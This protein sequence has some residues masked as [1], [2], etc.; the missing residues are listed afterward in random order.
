MG[1]PAPEI[2]SPGAVPPA[3]Q[4][5]GPEESGADTPDAPD[6]SDAPGTE[7]RKPLRA[8][9]LR[10]L[11]RVLDAAREAFATEG[12]SVSL[13]EIARRAGVGAGTVHRHF[14]AKDDLFR[15]VIARRLN[16]LTQ[17]AQD[18]A[19]A[20]DPGEAFFDFFNRLAA[21]A[22][23]NVALSAAL[24]NP[25]DVGEAILD[26]SK[27]LAEAHAVLLARAQEAGAV[28]RDVQAKDLH[29]IIGGALVMEQHLPPGST[30][31]GL[32]VVAD[33]L[34]P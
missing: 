28:R 15:A 21:D 7:T 16:D 9:A 6:I 18:L 24:T 5:L 19:A 14:P 4:S 27:A 29:A 23:H 32:T 12:P 2:A 13:D 17:V 11:N 26:A 8:D 30:G 22:R 1:K 25:A 33:G 20:P 34:R 3:G 31:R 10:N